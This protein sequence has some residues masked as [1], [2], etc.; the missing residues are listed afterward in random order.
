M[1][2]EDLKMSVC[3]EF[4]EHVWKPGSCKNCFCPR[5][6][7]QL[8]TPP[9]DLGGSRGLR[10]DL[11]GS[12][13]KVENT[14]LEDDGVIS[15]LYSKPT[16]AVKPTMITS[17]VA[18]VWAEGNLNADNS[19]VSKRVASR[20][21]IL[22][23]SGEEQRACINN[24]S[25]NIT[26][27]AIIQNTSN[28]YTA[29]QSPSFLSQFDVE[30]KAERNNSFR[31]MTFLTDV[32][33]H[34]DCIDVP[35]K[36]TSAFPYLGICHK[37]SVVNDRYVGSAVDSE[38]YPP[39]CQRGELS[40]SE[41]ASV[42]CAPD[43]ESEG[44]EYCSIAEYCG[45]SNIHKSLVNTRIKVPWLANENCPSDTLGQDTTVNAGS[46]S[47]RVNFSEE[48]NRI[49]NSDLGLQKQVRPSHDYVYNPLT[50]TVIFPLDS[51]LKSRNPF[52][53]PQGNSCCPLVKEFKQTEKKLVENVSNSAEHELSFQGTLRVSLSMLR[54]QKRKRHS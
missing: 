44:G 4:V 50:D 30:S 32:G 28:D 29:C 7:H 48:E 8:Q 45:Q 5:N 46:K 33:T 21:H 40:F 49:L 26:R 16:I 47:C 18:D 52:D 22:M 15:L 51:E 39:I 35:R 54:V 9:L 38:K 23:K 3:N 12:G 19:Q 42:P 6:F 27:K 2:Q 1:K 36:E 53:L 37:S 41:N 25:N 20:K 13:A 11:N 17:D 14:P 31:N 10:Q 43:I 34:E 24:F